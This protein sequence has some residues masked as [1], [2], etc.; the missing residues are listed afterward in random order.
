MKTIVVLA[1]LAISISVRANDFNDSILN[2]ENS[3]LNFQNSP[4]NFENSPQNFENSPQKFNNDR[5]IRD[6]NGQPKGYFVPKSDGGI[7]YFDLNGNRQGYQPA[8]RR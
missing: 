3:P 7:N 5:I 6:N 4:L 2:F 1:L 8:P